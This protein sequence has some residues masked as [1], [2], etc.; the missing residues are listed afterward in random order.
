MSLNVEGTFQNLQ[1]KFKM[2]FKV[3]NSRS[4]FAASEKVIPESYKPQRSFNAFIADTDLPISLSNE[5]S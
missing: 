5:K 4:Q 3:P 2:G 1:Q